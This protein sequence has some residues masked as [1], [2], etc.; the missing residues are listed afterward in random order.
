[1]KKQNLKNLAL[2]KNVVS[3]LK[4]LVIN[5]GA[6]GSPCSGDTAPIYSCH[7]EACFGPPK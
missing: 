5:G 4:I 3:N 7:V 6:T 1:M 2:H